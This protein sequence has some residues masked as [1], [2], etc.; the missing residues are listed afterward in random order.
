MKKFPGGKT[1][2][3]SH[4]RGSSTLGCLLFLI[5]VGLLGY[6]GFKFGEAGWD[7]LELRQKVKES[8]NWA[9]AGTQGKNDADIVQKV[10]VNAL[11]AG[12]E[13]TPRNVQIKHTPDTLTIIV[14]WKRTVELPYYTVP[15]NIRIMQSDTKRWHRGGLIIK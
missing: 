7:Y 6:V 5:I 13:L 9:V 4:S 14:T 8:L 15:L 11:D 12:I 1:G 10:I 2:F 3:F